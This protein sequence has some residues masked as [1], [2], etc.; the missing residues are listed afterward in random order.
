MALNLAP[1]LTPYVQADASPIQRG[2]AQIQEMRATKARMAQQ[3]A[4]FEA[5]QAQL[6]QVAAAKNALEHAKMQQAGAIEGMKEEG[7]LGRASERLDFDRSKEQNDVLKDYSTAASAGDLQGMEAMNPRLGNVGLQAAP[8]TEH[9]PEARAL[10]SLGPLS[11]RPP[12]MAH[13]AGGR[14]ETQPPM[15]LSG[16]GGMRLM[17]PQVDETPVLPA[18]DRATGRQLILRNGSPIAAYDLKGIEER[19][20][21]SL[22]D[23]ALLWANTLHD[24]ASVRQTQAR[25]AQALT[26]LGLPRDVAEKRAADEANR[27]LNR[28]QSAQN[29]ATVAGQK[30]D[31]QGRLLNKDEFGYYRYHV[32]SAAKD[33]SLVKVNDGLNAA[34]QL[35]SLAKSGNPIEQR[36]AIARSIKSMTTGAVSDY[37]T[38]NVMSAQSLAEEMLTELGRLTGDTTQSKLFM[39]RLAEMAMG[40]KRRFLERRLETAKAAAGSVQR[41]AFISPDRREK[42][43]EQAFLEV[44]GQA[45]NSSA[46]GEADVTVRPGTGHPYSGNDGGADRRGLPDL[47]VTDYGRNAPRFDPNDEDDEMDRL[48]ED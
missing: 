15:T 31:N 8:E 19:N 6:A 38:K 36:A 11:L 30:T 26:S 3:Q 47:E 42:L 32:D 45:P 39:A 44:M 24:E 1:F 21:Q 48:L 25:V 29:A 40:Q 16:L 35:L 33:G 17:H 14:P 34:D 37:E 2:L 9:V 7:R 23:T 28:E 41:S 43:A 12:E 5:E 27:I 4:Q 10:R 18:E 46:V 22:G 13:S 20:R